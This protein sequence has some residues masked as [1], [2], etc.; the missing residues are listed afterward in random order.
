M[1][2]TRATELAHDLHAQLER[3]RIKPMEAV[4]CVRVLLGMVLTTLTT[5]AADGEFIAPIAA[6]PGP[7]R[8]HYTV[9]EVAKYLSITPGRVYQLVHE[10]VLR[11]HRQGHGRKLYF[12]LDEV[13]R[14]MDHR[15]R[16]KRVA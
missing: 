2:A 6:P 1:T 11:P 15:P 12:R 9:A 3:E 5:C 7:P 16:R 8:K 4:E 14:T 13:D 10:G